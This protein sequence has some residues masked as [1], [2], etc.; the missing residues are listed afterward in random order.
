MTR[1]PVISR[2][3]VLA[4][5][6]AMGAAAMTSSLWAAVEAARLA[7]TPTQTIGPFYPVLR[8]LD[9]DMDLTVVSGQ[10]GRAKGEII[11]VVGRVVNG[12]GEPVSGARI[13]IWQANANGRYAH[14]SDINP[15][16]L[17]PNFQGFASQ[18]TDS[19]G[20][21]RFKTIKPG[22]YP[23]NPANPSSVRT[24]HIHFDVVGTQNRLLTQMYF[25]DEALNAG[26]ALFQR[27][28]EEGRQAVVGRRLPPQAG[29]ADGAVLIGWDIVLDKG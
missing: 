17:D 18:V 11:H 20:R 3:H 15:A 6:A 14:P 21:Y 28:D 12:N 8:P 22:A 26:D 9:Q 16:P 23:I 7:G 4:G 5:A 27:L 24:R 29:M 1:R 25:P 2:R 19:E 10:A 13:E